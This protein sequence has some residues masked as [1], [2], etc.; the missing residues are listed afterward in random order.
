MAN[1]A[2]ILGNSKDLPLRKFCRNQVLKSK[3]VLDGIIP[4]IYYIYISKRKNTAWREV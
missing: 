4:L 1:L 3:I 2:K